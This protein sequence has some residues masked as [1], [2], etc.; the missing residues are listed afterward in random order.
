MYWTTNFVTIEILL[1]IKKYLK[2]TPIKID[3]NIKNI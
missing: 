1:V 2:K 3:E